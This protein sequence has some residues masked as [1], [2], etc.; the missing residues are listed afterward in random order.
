MNFGIDYYRILLF[1]IRKFPFRIKI[2]KFSNTVS[3]KKFKN[4]KNNIEIVF[5]KL[6][7]YLSY[8]NI[9]YRIISLIINIFQ[10]LV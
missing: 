5:Q 3:N 9:K 4:F 7:R 10:T 2:S 1:D 6:I 8:R